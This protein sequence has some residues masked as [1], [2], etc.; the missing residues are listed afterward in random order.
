LITLTPVIA[1]RA[2]VHIVFGVLG[3]LL[4]RR[5]TK[6]WQVFVVTAPVHALGEALAVIPFGYTLH[7]ALVL[8]GVGTLL[9]HTIDAA[10]A[11]S[12]YHSLRRAGVS[13]SP[14]QAPR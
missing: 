12:L 11:L 13:L 3:A 10:I 5:G 14:S 7:A 6:P 4:Y 9:H 8:V 1:A 2:S